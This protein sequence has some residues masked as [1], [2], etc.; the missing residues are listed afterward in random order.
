MPILREMILYRKSSLTP[1]LLSFDDSDPTTRDLLLSIDR[2]QRDRWQKKEI[3]PVQVLEVLWNWGI[4]ID[5]SP[6]TNGLSLRFFLDRLWNFKKVCSDPGIE[7][8]S[9][10]IYNDTVCSDYGFK[11][12][13]SSERIADGMMTLSPSSFFKQKREKIRMTH[14]HKRSF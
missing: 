8:L 4:R 13:S 3:V 10:Y 6:P 11:R 5:D 7:E 2:K 9:S 14:P 12:N 1:H